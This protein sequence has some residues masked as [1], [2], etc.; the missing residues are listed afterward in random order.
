MSDNSLLNRIPAEVVENATTW[1]IPP[2]TEHGKILSSAEKEARERRERLLRREKETIE[3]VEIPEPEAPPQLGMT[4]EEMQAIFDTAEKDGFEQGHK[5]G[6][7]KG[8]SEG[9][10]AGRQQ[11][12]MEMR[13]QL[14]AEQQRF[15]KLANALLEPINAQD[16]DVEHL[17]LDVIC[18]LTQ[19]VVQRELLTDSSHIVSLVRNAVDALPIG[20]KNIRVCL[21]PDDL[22]AVETYAAEQQLAWSFFGD[23]EL[24]PGGCR[25]ET[26]ESRV[27]FS[28]SSRLQTVLEQFISKQLASGDRDDDEGDDAFAHGNM[29]HKAELENEKEREKKSDLKPD[30]QDEV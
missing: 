9:Y 5:E 24:L 1:V 19:S 8:N 26:P 29:L 20:S 22:A 21:N 27:D 11:G 15:Q 13:A 25:I 28:V 12:L 18:T 7:T 30:Q 10:E 4:A 14:V 23:G 16:T 2:I 6:F 17:L 3:T